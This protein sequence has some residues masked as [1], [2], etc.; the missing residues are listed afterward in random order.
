MLE[1][2]TSR[3][4]DRTRRRL[5]KASIRLFSARGYNGISV[6]QI[7]AAARVNKRMVYHYF[8]SKKA[9]YRA[10]LREVYNRIGRLEFHTIE[11]AATPKE[12][13]KRLLDSYFKFLYEN[14]EF[15]Q[16]I[17]WENVE[18]GRNISHRQFVMSMGP[19][20]ERFRTI[21]EEGTRLGDFRRDID[22]DHLLVHFIGSCFI[23]H[24]NRY[25]L[26]QGLDID[27]DSPIERNRGLSLLHTLLFDGISAVPRASRR[28][29]PRAA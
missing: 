7:V 1:R 4:P 6:D 14:Q 26:S 21:V 2:H 12:K 5:L 24:S 17:Q 19:F 27:L 22:I 8:G 20:L 13:L 3:N 16:L 23:Y 29:Q 25:T 10:A 18:R 28:V 11:G 15:T 9:I